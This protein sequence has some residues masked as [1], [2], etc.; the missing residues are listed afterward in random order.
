MPSAAS[1]L[2]TNGI[3]GPDTLTS[4]PTSGRPV[5]TAVTGRIG[6]IFD[7]SEYEAPVVSAHPAITN[8]VNAAVK[9]RTARS[10]HAGS[11][12]ARRSSL[13]ISDAVEGR[14]AKEL[15]GSAARPRARAP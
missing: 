10:R 3:S 5:A 6:A 14:R 8:A 12:R 9:A 2:A 1:A 11:G 15:S 7:T 13:R 4:T